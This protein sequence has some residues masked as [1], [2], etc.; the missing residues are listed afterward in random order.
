M[1]EKRRESG[2]KKGRRKREGEERGE[3]K[4]N[5]GEWVGMILINGRKKRCNFFY[6]YIYYIDVALLEFFLFT[7]YVILYMKNLFFKK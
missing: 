5:S 1:A 7:Y 2:R 4:D 3:R 6:F